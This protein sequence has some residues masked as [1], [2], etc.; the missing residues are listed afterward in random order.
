MTEKCAIYVRVSSDLQDYKRQLSDLKNFAEGNK[1]ILEDKYIY[2]DKLSGYKNENEREGLASLLKEVTEFK[3][4][5]VLVW[6]MSRLARRQKTLIEL[7][8]FFQEHKINVYFYQQRFWLLD[9]TGKISP[10][11]GLSTAFFGWYADYEARLTRER[12]MSAKS[13]NVK[14]GKYNGGK[15]PFG[16]TLDQ[17]NRFIINT[18]TIDSLN[19][20][21]AEIVQEVFNLYESGLTCSKI[22]RICR[23][24]NYPKIVCNT[25]T[26]A[27]VLRNT[28]YIGYKEVKLGTRPTPPLISKS[29]FNLVQELVESNKTKADKGKKHT[30]LLRG[31]LKCAVCGE[32]YV[33]KQTD[34]AYICPKNS[35]SN[36]TNKGSSCI[37]SNISISTLDG[38]IWKLVK[39]KLVYKTDAE[40]DDFFIT[41]TQK[42]NHIKKQISDFQGLLRKIDNERKRINNI[43]QNGGSSLEE[44]LIELGKIKNEKTE[45]HSKIESLEKELRYNESILKESNEISKRKEKIDLIDDRK[46]LKKFIKAVI[47]EIIF[48][49]INL[50]K[51]I[52]IVEYIDGYKDLILFNSVAKKGNE[53]KMLD[54]RFYN[55]NPNHNLFYVIESDSDISF[56]ASTK[57]LMEQNVGEELP[58]RIPLQLFSRICRTHDLFDFDLYEVIIPNPMNDYNKVYSFDEIMMHPDVEFK[59]STQ[60]FKKLTY[61]KELK[62][63]RFNRR[64]KKKT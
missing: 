22:S 10:Q 18:E 54:Y 52:V 43:Y 58:E 4:K 23:S 37:G 16:Y 29:Q 35:G 61:F 50:F 1:F 36:K 9:E 31:I 45:C 13:N 53:F 11:A 8:E 20:S 63:E 42:I 2:E 59:I 19:T 34:D 40:I 56:E 28:Q 25:H 24:K 3:I 6:E 39:S 57:Y 17:E 55:F 62:R 32:F 7:T 51:T 30:F 48:F 41:S 33:G 21:E 49:K 44:Y 60:A 38:I 14:L 27:R 46:Q 47:R 12:F 5:T 15:I 64:K 26:L